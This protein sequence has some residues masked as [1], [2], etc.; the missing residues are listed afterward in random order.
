MDF[1]PWDA[2]VEGPAAHKGAERLNAATRAKA[3]R[4]EASREE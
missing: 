1:F 4:R 3:P 2:W